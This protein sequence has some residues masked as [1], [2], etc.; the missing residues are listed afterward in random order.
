MVEVSVLSLCAINCFSFY[1]P[2]PLA[3]L[4]QCSGLLEF[5]L[6]AWT[7][8]CPEEVLRGGGKSP[9]CGVSSSGTSLAP[10]IQRADMDGTQ[11]TG[12]NSSN[13]LKQ[14]T[15]NFSSLSL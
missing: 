8:M 12:G 9:E 15:R 10:L 11:I 3:L 5:H 1:K 13:C 4:C 7:V 14:R 6:V 2:F